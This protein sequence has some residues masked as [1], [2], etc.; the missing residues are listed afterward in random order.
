MLVSRNPRTGSTT[1]LAWG[2]VA[3]ESA[4]DVNPG[5]SSFP[6][7]L[8]V[9]GVGAGLP[10]PNQLV[11]D[12]ASSERQRWI[13]DRTSGFFLEETNADALARV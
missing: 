11:Q 3:C 10:V 1:S 7:W 4:A 5:G 8:T 6:S 12:A 13:R 9:V 2:C